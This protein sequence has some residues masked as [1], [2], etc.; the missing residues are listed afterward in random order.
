L[1]LDFNKLRNNFIFKLNINLFLILYFIIN[2]SIVIDNNFKEK[3]LLNSKSL[4]INSIN[5]KNKNKNI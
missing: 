1:D 4:I 3:N 5:R 2:K